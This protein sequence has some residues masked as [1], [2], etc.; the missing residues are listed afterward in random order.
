MDLHGPDI[1]N[2]PGRADR[3]PLLRSVFHAVSYTQLR[4]LCSLE[5][6][7]PVV[8]RSRHN[9]QERSM[10]TIECLSTSHINDSLTLVSEA[11]I[12]ARHLC[13]VMAGIFIIENWLMEVLKMGD[14]SLDLLLA[15]PSISATNI[16]NYHDS[17][18]QLVAVVP[19]CP[20]WLIRIS[21][22]SSVAS[23]QSLANTAAPHS[24]S[25]STRLN[26][27]KQYLS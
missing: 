5:T 4:R 2:V 27:K 21:R 24:H 3:R 19:L 12:T 18:K 25:T 7:I 9:D 6:M 26:D 1:V 15:R 8:V 16:G 11:T 17:I 22:L 13:I 10:P 14:V 20:S 23:D